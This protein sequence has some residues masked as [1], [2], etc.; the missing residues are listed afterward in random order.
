MVGSPPSRKRL[1]A[2]VVARS[3][4]SEGLGQRLFGGERLDQ[5]QRLATDGVL[6]AHDRLGNCTKQ[7]TAV[8]NDVANPD[9]TGVTSVELNA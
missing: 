8:S 9:R 1:R 5:F 4:L 6:H 3:V 7:R 2:S